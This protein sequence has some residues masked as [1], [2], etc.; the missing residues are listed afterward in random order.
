MEVMWSFARKHKFSPTLFF[1]FFPPL[2]IAKIMG[3]NLK[4]H[5][6]NESMP[7]EIIMVP[8]LWASTKE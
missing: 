8:I 4:L 7:F 3:S 1:F 5:V 2:L 6:L